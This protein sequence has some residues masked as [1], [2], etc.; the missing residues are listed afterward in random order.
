[1]TL[2]LWQPYFTNQHLDRKGPTQES[3]GVSVKISCAHHFSPLVSETVLPLLPICK[4][5]SVIPIE[6]VHHSVERKIDQTRIA[7]KTS[8]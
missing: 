3:M 8:I 4:Y 2:R 1:M 6:V 5:S 7:N